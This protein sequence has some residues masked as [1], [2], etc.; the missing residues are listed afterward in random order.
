MSKR[1]IVA[2]RSNCCN[3]PIVGSKSSFT[4][5]ICKFVVALSSPLAFPDYDPRRR[6]KN[7]EPMEDWE[8]E[9]NTNI[10]VLE[11]TNENYL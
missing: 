7:Y 8:V 4:F 3:R 1:G 11:E 5:R 9:E 2:L 6:I 10:N